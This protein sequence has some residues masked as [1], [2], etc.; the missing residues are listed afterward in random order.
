MKSWHNTTLIILCV[1]CVA[2]PPRIITHP[3]EL[4][5]AAEGKPAKFFIQATGTEKLDY[6]WQW[7]PAEEKGGHEDWQQCD[8]KLCKGATLSIAKVGKSN[9]GSYRCIVSNFAGN[10]TSIPANLTVGKRSNF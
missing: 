2:D 8:A 5:D 3:Q 9:E 7:K 4:R 6:H 1:V 10:Q